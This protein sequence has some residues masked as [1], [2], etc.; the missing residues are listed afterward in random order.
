MSDRR[1]R[2]IPRSTPEPGEKT[3]YARNGFVGLH[4]DSRTGPTERRVASHRRQQADRAL[5]IALKDGDTYLMQ[6]VSGGVLAL[7][8]PA[9][10]LDVISRGE[11]VATVELGS[12]ECPIC[13][14]SEPHEHTPAEIAERPQIDGARNEFE[15]AARSGRLGLDTPLGRMDRDTPWGEYRSRAHQDSWLYW[16][17]AW[18]AARLPSPSPMDHD[19]WRQLYMNEFPRD[20]SPSP[21]AS[22]EELALAICDELA[23]KRHSYELGRIPLSTLQRIADIAAKTALGGRG[24]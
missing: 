2:D 10:A 1:L 22:V 14:Y 12:T 17:V 21:F 6:T 7:R 8:R 5:E 19:E 9:P 3:L 18:L 24:R 20:L 23:D 13:G 4:A 15:A 16:R 11:A